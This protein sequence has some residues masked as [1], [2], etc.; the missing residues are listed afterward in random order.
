M[1]EHVA[2][3]DPAELARR[4]RKVHDAVASARLEGTQVRREVL[5]VARERYECAKK[6]DSP[7]E[8]W[9][10]LRNDMMVETAIRAQLKRFA[11][12]LTAA[13]LAH[14]GGTRW[15]AE[16]LGELLR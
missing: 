5:C 13:Q 4:E 1:E 16:A 9:Q 2:P 12:L 15:L 10:E 7:F 14:R 11:E 3:L 6:E 8:G